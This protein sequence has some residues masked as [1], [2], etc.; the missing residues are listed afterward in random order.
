[1]KPACFKFITAGRPAPARCV[2]LVILR[3][4]SAREVANEVMLRR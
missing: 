3:R 4:F 2:H 1:M